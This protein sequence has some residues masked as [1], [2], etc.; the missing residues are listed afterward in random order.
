M[1][2]FQCQCGSVLCRGLINGITHNS[3]TE[4]ESAINGG[5]RA[6]LLRQATNG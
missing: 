2:P 4:R 5:M 3:L 6:E 1:E